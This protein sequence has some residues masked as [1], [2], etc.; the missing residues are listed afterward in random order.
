MIKKKPFVKY[1]LENSKEAVITV[2]LNEAQ[3]IWLNEMKKVLEQPKDSTALKQLALIGSKVLL[4]PKTSEILGVIYA[5]KR[6]NKRLGI[7]EY[8]V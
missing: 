7:V 8:D 4:E 6:K 5:N 1:N 3:V 2:K